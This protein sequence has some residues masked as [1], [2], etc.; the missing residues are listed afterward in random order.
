[1]GNF[2][3][4]RKQPA[5]PASIISSSPSISRPHT[6]STGTPNQFTNPRRPSSRSRPREE[7]TPASRRSMN[8]VSP[9]NTP[10]PPPYSLE[11]SKPTP[12]PTPPPHDTPPAL[13]HRSTTSTAHRHQ[14]Q[15]AS[16]VPSSR[17]NSGNS[18]AENLRRV[19]SAR[20]AV[21][22]VQTNY[23]SNTP[24]NFNNI[25]GFVAE[26]VPTGVGSRY[27][28]YETFS[29][30]GTPFRPPA[31]APNNARHSGE[32]V[33]SPTRSQPPLRRTSVENPL[34]LLRKFDTVCI[35]DGKVP[36]SL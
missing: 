26:M 8:V 9:R 27:T 36:N 24:P 19:G 11:D 25:G 13:S 17:T 15:R 29:P 1:M 12:P 33:T 31:P 35:V 4:R 3:S 6:L 28:N 30:G 23:R 34:E 5:A 32:L 10:A 18:D 20:P 22:S 21:P 14:S 2:S 16:H 7:T